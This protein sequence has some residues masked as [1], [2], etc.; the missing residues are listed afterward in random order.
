MFNKR[1][2]LSLAGLFTPGYQ[3]FSELPNVSEAGS[4]K[5]LFTKAGN[6]ISPFKN[7]KKVL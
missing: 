3:M 5:V 1:V 6:T 7:A 2:L 4:E